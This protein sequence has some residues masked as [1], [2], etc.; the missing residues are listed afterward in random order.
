MYFIFQSLE[1][2]DLQDVG[3]IHKPDFVAHP[4]KYFSESSAGKRQ[5]ADTTVPTLPSVTDS[6]YFFPLFLKLD[7]S[8]YGQVAKKNEISQPN[9]QFTTL[10]LPLLNSIDLQMRYDERSLFPKFILE[11][12]AKMKATHALGMRVSRG[13]RARGDTLQA[14][15]R[16]SH[17]VPQASNKKMTSWKVLLTSK[18]KDL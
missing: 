1:T 4:E 3:V 14:R 10:T 11:M 13:A 12:E 16:G 7:L 9:F 2:S 8:Y 5:S 6:K 17:E 15:S 18:G